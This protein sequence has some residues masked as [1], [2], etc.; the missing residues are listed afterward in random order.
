MPQPKTLADSFIRFGQARA[1]AKEL[2]KSGKWLVE[3]S[4]PGHFSILARLPVAG[5]KIGTSLKGRT[6]PGFCFVRLTADFAS[7]GATFFRLFEPAYRSL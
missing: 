2:A 5:P 3:N 7:P 1:M 6:I 4:R